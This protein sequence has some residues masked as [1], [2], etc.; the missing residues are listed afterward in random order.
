MIAT[1]VERFAY[2]ITSICWIGVA[3]DPT[4]TALT[5]ALFMSGLAVS[6][7]ALKQVR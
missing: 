5:S 1:F 3:M 6:I 2:L 4:E 7:T